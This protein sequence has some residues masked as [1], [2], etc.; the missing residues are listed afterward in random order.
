MLR[1]LFFLLCGVFA[2]VAIPARGAVDFPWVAVG[3]AGNPADP[4]TGFG[5][6]DYDYEISAYDV[7]NAQYVEFLNTVDP[8]GAN[9][10]RLWNRSMST[11]PGGGIDFDV[12]APAGRKYSAKAGFEKKPFTFGTFFNALRFINWLNNGQGSASTEQGAYT[13]LGGTPAPSNGLDVIRSASAKIALASED[14]WYKAAYYQGSGSYALYATGGDTP[15][16]ACAPTSA[17][18]CANYNNAV[19]GYTDVGAYTGSPSHYGTYDQAGNIWNWN[20]S[21]FP[22]HTRGLR[23]NAFVHEAGLLASTYR[24]NR[25]PWIE[26]LHV[27]FRVVRVHPRGQLGGWGIA[28]SLAAAALAMGGFIYWLKSKKLA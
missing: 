8:S 14:E 25:E 5:K 2:A 27:G 9:P 22:D 1:I 12:N 6:V 13:L 20:E 3:D 10:L 28:I 24:Y 11:E 21:I 15:P 17:P 7:T 16:T 4:K 23:G 18:R 19:G 26:G